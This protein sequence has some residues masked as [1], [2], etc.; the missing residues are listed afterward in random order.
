MKAELRKAQQT[1]TQLKS[2]LAAI[3]KVRGQL[4]EG[5]R[6]KFDERIQNARQWI[7]DEITKFK[8]LDSDLQEYMGDE[9]YQLLQTGNRMGRA[10]G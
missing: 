6:P 9:F 7:S 10:V 1:I 4:G 3:E 5:D 8:D 2:N